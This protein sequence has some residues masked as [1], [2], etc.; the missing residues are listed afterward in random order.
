MI[1]LQVNLPE[2]LRRAVAEAAARDAVSIDQFVA[3]ALAEKLAALTTE[4]YLARRAARSHR[5]KFDAAIAKVPD[6]EPEPD[7]RLS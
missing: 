6:A 3:T 7:D 1:R 5:A 2:S 4:D